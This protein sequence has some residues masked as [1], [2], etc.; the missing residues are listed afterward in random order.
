MLFSRGLRALVLGQAV[1]EIDEQS[2][3]RQDA[4]QQLQDGGGQKQSQQ[5]LQHAHLRFSERS[6]LDIK[7]P[8]VDDHRKEKGA[9]TNHEAI[10]K[11][12]A[13]QRFY[14]L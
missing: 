8:G 12:D 5:G 6:G 13:P 9:R 3:W 2:S 11:H 4:R 14:R 1:P 10:N 7:K